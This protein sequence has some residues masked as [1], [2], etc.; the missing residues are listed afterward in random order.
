MITNNIKSFVLLKYEI[1]TSDSDTWDLCEKYPAEVKSR[2]AWRCAEDVEHLAKGYP[3]AEECI[4]IAKLYRD[5]LAT[6][7]ELDRAWND[8]S[9]ITYA[10]T[11][12]Y[13]GNAASAAASAAAYAAYYAAYHA[14]AKRE[15]KW[16]LYIGWLIQE[17]CEWESKQ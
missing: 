10:T 12:Y 16:K 15:E 4:R 8:S 3:K 9:A 11:A 14:T 13:A 2:W 17:L 7:E 5:G 6:K 1:I